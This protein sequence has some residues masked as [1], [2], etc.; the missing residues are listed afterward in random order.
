MTRFFPDTAYDGV[1]WPIEKV[2]NDMAEHV[3]EW[4][5]HLSPRNLCYHLRISAHIY[6]DY[7]GRL[8]LPPNMYCLLAVSEC[9]QK[10]I[11]WKRLHMT[12][13]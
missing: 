11:R 13:N 9:A 4:I 10:A 12:Q 3:T 1:Q 2:N 6:M 5:G 8:L 7:Y